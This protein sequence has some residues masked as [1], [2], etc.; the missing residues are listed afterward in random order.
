[1][2]S[3][4]DFYRMDP[5]LMPFPAFRFMRILLLENLTHNMA[6]VHI[7]WATFESEAIPLKRFPSR[8][9]LLV[10]MGCSFHKMDA[11]FH[12]KPVGQCRLRGTSNPQQLKPPSNWNTKKGKQNIQTRK[13]LLLRSKKNFSLEDKTGTSDCG[14]GLKLS[15]NRTAV[16]VPKANK[17]T[18]VE[19]KVLNQNF[20]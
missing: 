2:P 9:S 15:A 1:M 18:R 7:M 17:L 19:S 5:S 16:K 10:S 14:F 11:F 4:F 13:E 6:L 20:R 8:D 3:K 12:R